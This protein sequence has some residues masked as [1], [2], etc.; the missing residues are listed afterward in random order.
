[1][2]RLLISGVVLLGLAGTSHGQV[3]TEE[4]QAKLEAKQQQKAATQP[5][6]D[7]DLRRIIDQ[8]LSENEEVTR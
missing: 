5:N 6:D 8:L 1:M 4:A 3:T 7:A 2:K